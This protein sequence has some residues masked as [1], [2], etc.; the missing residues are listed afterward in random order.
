M[1]REVAPFPSHLSSSFIIRHSLFAIRHSVSVGV[2]EIQ[3]DSAKASGARTGPPASALGYFFQLSIQSLVFTPSGGFT[4]EGGN[5]VIRS[6]IAKG[7]WGTCLVIPMMA[8]SI[9]L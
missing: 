3:R 1:N 5:T 8:G 6:R 2:N 4:S 7:Y 9:P